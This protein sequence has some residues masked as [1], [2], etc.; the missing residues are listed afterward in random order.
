MAAY[1]VTTPKRRL[2]IARGLSVEFPRMWAV[3]DLDAEGVPP[4][5]TGG[6]RT[7]REAKA[8]AHKIAAADRDGA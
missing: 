7:L 5:L 3:Y 2:L 4:A 1:L 8:E 6:F